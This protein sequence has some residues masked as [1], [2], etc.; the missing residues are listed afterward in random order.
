MRI[1]VLFIGIMLVVTGLV[2]AIVSAIFGPK[3]TT[4]G[5]VGIAICLPPALGTLVLTRWLTARHPFG[6]LIGLAVG[7]VARLF[8]VLVIAAGV[9]LATR[10]EPGSPLAEPLTF[11]L[12]V[13]FVYLVALITE[14]ALLVRPID[15]ANRTE[16]GG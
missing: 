12:W 7:T 2:V 8:I 13:L 15:R 11:W 9:F 10:Q 6:M 1:A 16:A 14:T 3:H 5:F 4:C